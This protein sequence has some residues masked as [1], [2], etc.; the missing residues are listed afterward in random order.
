MD[1]EKVLIADD[2][3]G[4]LFVLKEF[5]AD[6]DM[7][8][9]TAKDGKEATVSFIKDSPT[10][11]VM[12]INMPGKD[13][14]SILKDIKAQG[15]TCMVIIMTADSS[16]TNTL[17][18][19]KH[20]AFD[21]ITKPYDLDELDIIVEKAREASRLKN[22]VVKLKERLKETTKELT[23]AG[24]SKEIQ[25]VFKDVGKV[26]SQDVT[27]LILG[28]SGTGKELLAKIIYSNSPRFEGPFI[29]VNSAAVSKDL[30]ESELFGFEKGAFTGASET[31]PGKF[32]LADGGTLFLD[33]VGDMSLDVQSKLLRAI[34][35]Q[36][37]YRVGGSRPIKVDVRIIT[38]TNKNLEEAVKNGTF[39]E[40]LLYR[41][42][43]VTFNLPPLR[44]RTGDIEV[45]SDF[46]LDKFCIDMGVEHKTLS[47]EATK[48]LCSYRWPGNVRELENVLRRATLMSHTNVITPND[49]DL[50]VS[51]QKNLSIE[52]IISAKLEPFIDRVAK[53]GTTDLYDSIVPYMER[54]LITLV[55]KKT[56]Y[57]QVKAAELLG[58][59]RNTLR[60]KIKELDI[61]LKRA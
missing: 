41:L 57:N 51:T 7:D 26:S 33:E 22:S 40:D 60:K 18:A 59:N 44:E 39:R 4:I 6:K 23:F 9:V 2:D 42:N 48:D 10:L 16:M 17:Q 31:R 58:I 24:K 53:K 37:F 28:E 46:F 50:P 45:L 21:Y 29:A 15:S 1:K 3:E 52:D 49:L 13:G 5:F 11:A 56:N 25:N 47:N 12:D 8:V 27:A 36:E 20:G 32:E 30:M 19:M 55:L 38:A 61:K 54:P 35:E 34:Q 14:L 43:V